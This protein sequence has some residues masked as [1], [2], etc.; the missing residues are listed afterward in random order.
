MKRLLLL[1]MLCALAGCDDQ[2]MRQQNRYD[3]YAPSNF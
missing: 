2:S 3:A 1:A